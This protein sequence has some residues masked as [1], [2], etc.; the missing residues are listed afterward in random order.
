V[1]DCKT[2]GTA[3][4]R[5]GDAATDSDLVIAY[6]LYA[7]KDV[8]ALSERSTQLLEDAIATLIEDTRAQALTIADRPRSRTRTLC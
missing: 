4:V 2:H 1:E 3:E 5:I 8:R 7:L 6:L